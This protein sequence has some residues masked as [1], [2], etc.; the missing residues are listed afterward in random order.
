MWAFADILN[1]ALG[2]R[3]SCRHDIVKVPHALS[4]VILRAGLLVGATTW[5]CPRGRGGPI[6]WLE[7]VELAPTQGRIPHAAS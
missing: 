4:P 6:T 7:K 1:G 5:S 3:D 2:H